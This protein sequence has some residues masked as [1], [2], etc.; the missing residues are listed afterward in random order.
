MER[1]QFVSLLGGAALG[2]LTALPVY[3]DPPDGCGVPVARDDGFRRVQS[4]LRNPWRDKLTRRANHFGFAENLSSPKIKNISLFP[5]AKSG[6]HLSPSRP[7]KRG[8]S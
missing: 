5:K 1:R 2:P 7:G 6:A 4:I 3:A 8:V